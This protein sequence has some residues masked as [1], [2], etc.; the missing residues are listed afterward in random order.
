MTYLTV[1]VVIASIFV[2]TLFAFGFLWAYRKWQ[3][4][5]GRR[6]PIEN[7]VIYGA[8]E[9]LRKRIEDHTD[10]ML[11]ALV[12]LFFLGPYFLAAWALPKL[13]WRHIS[14]DGGD[15]LLIV[16]FV[17]LASWAIA[18]IIRQGNARRQCIAGL[19]AELFTAQEL[20][21]LMGAGCTVLHDIPGENFNLDHVV[22]GP[23]GVYVVETKSVRKP[24]RNKNEDHY[25]VAYDG[26]S[27]RFPDCISRKPIVQARRQAQWLAS[28]LKQAVG[29]PIPVIATVALPGWWIDGPRESGT[30]FVRIFNPAGRGAAFMAEGRGTPLL[31]EGSA[32][33]TAQALL[34]RYPVADK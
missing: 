2:P 29:R 1:F 32:A 12:V 10:G 23:R 8:G 6:S 27:L 5:E 31:D 20:N 19:K 17:M 21:R 13:D 3:D 33:L 30:D 9:Q 18:R 25:K 16:A 7:K 4:R 14:F 11:S 22:I 34:M 24:K 26:E 28:Y 15:A